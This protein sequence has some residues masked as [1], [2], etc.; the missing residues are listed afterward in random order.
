MTSASVLLGIHEI[1]YPERATVRK[2]K[3]VPVTTTFPRLKSSVYRPVAHKNDERNVSVTLHVS[4]FCTSERNIITAL[5]KRS[6]SYNRNLHQ[7]RHYRTIY[8][9]AKCRFDMVILH[10]TNTGVVDFC[11]CLCIEIYV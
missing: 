5:D 7:W 11:Y 2:N 4:V 8:M 10:A 3:N 9:V 6:T 1:P